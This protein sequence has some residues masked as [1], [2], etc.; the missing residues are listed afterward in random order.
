MI[1]NL[2]NQECFTYTLFERMEPRD[3]PLPIVYYFE[4]AVDGHMGNIFMKDMSAGASTLGI[5]YR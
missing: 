4:R 3:F 2:H 5:F 1:I